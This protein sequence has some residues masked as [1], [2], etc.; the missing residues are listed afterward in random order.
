MSPTVSAVPH[1]GDLADAARLAAPP[2]DGWL[3]LSTGINPHAYPAAIPPEA[4]T[5]LPQRSRLDALLAAARTAYAVPPGSGIVA[6]PGTQAIIQWL[7]RLVPAERVTVVGP[8]Y[9]EHAA[10]WRP[11]A[12]TA[13]ADE[14]P[15]EGLAVVVNPNNPTGRVHAPGTLRAAATRDAPDGVALIVDEAF[16]DLA[17]EASVAG[18]PGTLVLKS[19]GK[20]FG[21]P[22][23]R[24][25]FAIG[26]PDVMG[27]LSAALG[28]W[29]VSGPAIEIGTAALADAAWI[30]TMRRQ[31]ADERAAL[32]AVLGAAGLTVIGGTDLFRLVECRDAAGLHRALARHGIWTRRFEHAPRWLR[33]GFPGAAL[34]RLAAAL[35]A[36]THASIATRTQS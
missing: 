11:H 8:T 30:A 5:R 10:A 35:E 24:L 26:A 32:D 14:L 6:A 31:L 22:G 29:A 25:G 21:L 4:L 17:P 2:K 7:P 19:F 15:A 28:P 33:I 23:V 9:A 27:R 16:G 36:V 18:A 1:G 34:P 12:A 13:E 20:F 3:D